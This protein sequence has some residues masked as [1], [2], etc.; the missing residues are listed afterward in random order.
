MVSSSVFFKLM[1]SL[2][3]LNQVAFAKEETITCKV[4]TDCFKLNPEFICQKADEKTEEGECVH[5][6]LFPLTGREWGATIA[7][8]FIMTLS[9][10][11]GIGGGGIAIPL[12]SYGYGF[13]M[14]PA[15]AISSFSIMISTLAR[16]FYNF[17]EKNPDKPNA[18]CIDYGL[19]NVMMPLTLLGSLIGAY[20]YI[21]FPDL[22]LMIILTLL[23]L[24]LTC[25]SGRKGREIY[26]KESQQN[27]SEDAVELSEVPQPSSDDNEAQA[28]ASLQKEESDK[29]SEVQAEGGQEPN[30]GSLK[31]VS[32]D[33]VQTS[34]ENGQNL[35]S[36]SDDIIIKPSEKPSKTNVFGSDSE[37]GSEKGGS[38]TPPT[39]LE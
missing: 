32:P 27:V 5:K 18:T 23:L 13:G 39:A 29:Q 2:T 35:N 25:E 3:F 38:T 4:T 11:A 22:I 37:K 34:D 15:I 6:P 24:V 10:V 20:F 36:N 26:L 31:Q 19:T 33:F 9:N 17:N 12:V 8:T 7:F 28:Q 30:I 1:L 16:F 14:K 21:S